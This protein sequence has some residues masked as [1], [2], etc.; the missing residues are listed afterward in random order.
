MFLVSADETSA[1]NFEGDVFGEIPALRRIASI[2]FDALP[3]IYHVHSVGYSH[4]VGRTKLSVSTFVPQFL[5]TSKNKFEKVTGYLAQL[6]YLLDESSNSLIVS[7]LFG[8]SSIDKKFSVSE[9]RTETFFDVIPSLG[10]LWQPFDN[11]CFFI[12]STAGI[13]FRFDKN[14]LRNH[15]GARF[16]CSVSIGYAIYDGGAD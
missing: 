10:Y 11:N 1:Q 16:N 15:I 14:I 6:G 4:Q 8:A 3:L 12:A 7:V 13:D 2:Q 5:F 9:K